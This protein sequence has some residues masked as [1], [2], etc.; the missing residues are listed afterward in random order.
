MLGLQTITIH[1]VLKR[2]NLHTE[3]RKAE[4]GGAKVDELEKPSPRGRPAEL[5]AH[6]NARRLQEE[7]VC[8][9]VVEPWWLLPTGTWDLEKNSRPLSGLLNDVM[10]HLHCV[11]ETCSEQRLGGAL[12]RCSPAPLTHR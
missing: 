2:Q 6:G 12:L 7:A 1:P 10:L 11:P 9:A 4:S 5:T 8:R 3:E